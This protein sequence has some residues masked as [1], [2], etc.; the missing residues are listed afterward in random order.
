MSI[1]LSFRENSQT[2]KPHFQAPSTALPS[3]E[4]SSITMAA[5][6]TSKSSWEKWAQC[7]YLTDYDLLEH[8]PKYHVG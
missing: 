2:K 1:I 5:V 3:M 6:P 7:H 4:F 8:C